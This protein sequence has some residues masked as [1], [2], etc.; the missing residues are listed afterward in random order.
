MSALRKASLFVAVASMTIWALV[1]S[2]SA[3]TATNNDPKSA[4]EELTRQMVIS[5]KPSAAAHDKADAA[6]LNALNSPPTEA[7]RKA[8]AAMSK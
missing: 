2:P 3:Q 4:M 1:Q 6:M 7:D 8:T 5:P